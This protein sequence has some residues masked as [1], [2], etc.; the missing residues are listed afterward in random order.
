[1]HRME[2]KKVKVINLKMSPKKKENNFFIL[3]FY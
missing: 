2:G 3:K 1:M